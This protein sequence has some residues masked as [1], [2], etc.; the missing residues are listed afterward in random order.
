MFDLPAWKFVRQSAL[1]RIG[2]DKT[3]NITDMGII[4]NRWTTAINRYF[5]LFNGLEVINCTR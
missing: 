2:I 4:V 3:G 1:Q 5:A